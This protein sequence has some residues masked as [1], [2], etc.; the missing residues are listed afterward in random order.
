VFDKLS[1]KSF[2][3]SSRTGEYANVEFDTYVDRRGKEE[4]LDVK[5]PLHYLEAGE[6]QPLVLVH[7]IGQSLYTWR[8]NFEELSRHFH[9]YAIDLPGHGFSGKPQISYSVEEFALALEAFLNA[10]R[11]ERAHFCVF[12]ESAIYLLDFVI[13]NP[14]RSGRVVLLSPI[15]SE[16]SKGNRR[17]GVQSVFG[18]AAQKMMLSPA[19]MRGVLGQCY[20]DQTLVTEE[21]VQEYLNGIADKEFKQIARLCTVNFYDEDVVANIV[22]VKHPVLLCVGTDDKVTG[23]RENS[24]LSLGFENGSLLAVRNCGFLVHEEKPEKVNEAVT[25]FLRME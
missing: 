4:V 25:A 7:G 16:G 15:T 18:T 3:N 14:K 1:S 12:G 5:F 22:S 11:L 20:F 13:H 8:K 24:A 19:L 6:G 10:M 17:G 2:R 9:V 21:A 23:G